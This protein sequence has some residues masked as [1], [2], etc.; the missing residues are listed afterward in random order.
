MSKNRRF[1][2]SAKVLSIVLALA[3]V[4]TAFGAFGALVL[5]GFTGTAEAATDPLPYF[6]VSTDGTGNGLSPA[7]PAGRFMDGYDF[8]IDNPGGT[9]YLMEGTHD[10]DGQITYMPEWLAQGKI[11]NYNG[12]DAKLKYGTAAGSAF[13]LPI[14]PSTLL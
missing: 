7:T 6:Y 9:V 4:V 5:P 12:E 14:R 13:S 11:K 8:L 2:K 1:I 3:M 10:F